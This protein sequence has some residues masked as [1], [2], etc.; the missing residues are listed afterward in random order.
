MIQVPGTTSQ[1]RYRVMTHHEYKK[2]PFFFFHSFFVRFLPSFPSSLLLTSL[3]PFL[4]YILPSFLPSFL[5][6]FL[7]SSLHLFLPSF[8]PSPSTVPLYAF[9]F[10]LT[11]PVP[12]C[13]TS[14]T[15]IYILLSKQNK[16]PGLEV[17]LDSCPVVL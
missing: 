10:K 14:T 12:K 15:L 4:V 7:L 11:L 13:I 2:V 5:L 8:F 6:P 3:P 16:L 17:H 9:I 1:L